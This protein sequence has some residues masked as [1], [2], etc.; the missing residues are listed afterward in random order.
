MDTYHKVVLRSYLDQPAEYRV[1]LSVQQNVPEVKFL[2]PSAQAVAF[3][4]HGNELAVVISGEN[5]WFCH[6]IQVGSHKEK[7]EAG[8]VSRRSIQFNCGLNS[9]DLGF[10]AD[11][12]KVKVNLENHFYNRVKGNV[13]VTHKV[14]FNDCVIMLHMI[15]TG[16]R[17]ANYSSIYIALEQA[18][19]A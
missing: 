7:V 16:H 5:L 8:D 10:S 17:Q 1:P 2:K 19:H 6:E 14:G 9:E 3:H 12:D 13:Q 11:S 4:R 18:L 15:D